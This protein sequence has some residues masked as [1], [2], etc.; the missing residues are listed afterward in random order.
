MKDGWR[1]MAG[2]LHGLGMKLYRGVVGV[3]V[4]LQRR[5]SGGGG[6][7]ERMEEGRWCTLVMG[8]DWALYGPEVRR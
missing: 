8:L 5:V 2:W 7:S 3:R 4:A 1:E 6:S